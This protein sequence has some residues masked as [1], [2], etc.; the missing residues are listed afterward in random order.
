MLFLCYH[1]L[2]QLWPV[3]KEKGEGIKFM[4]W[5]KTMQFFHQVLKSNMGS[6]KQMTFSCSINQQVCRLFLKSIP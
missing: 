6:T 3:V 1:M 2:V 5:T 4:F